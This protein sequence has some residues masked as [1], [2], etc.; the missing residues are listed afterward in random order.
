MTPL[1]WLHLSDLHFQNGDSFERNIVLEELLKDVGEQIQREQFCLD[2]IAVTGDIAYSGKT[3][4]Y[5]L[6]Q[7]YFDRL[8]KVTATPKERLFVVPGNHDLDRSTITAGARQIGENFDQQDIVNDVLGSTRDMKLMMRRFKAFQIFLKKYNLTRPLD[9]VPPPLYW[10]YEF[11]HAGRK[12]LLSGLNS[13]WI[14]GSDEDDRNRVVIGER[15]VRGALLVDNADNEQTPTI[16]IVLMHHPF[17]LLREFDE[18]I[19]AALLMD[20]CDFIL[21]G[22][23]HKTSLNQLTSPDNACMRIAGGAC[24]KSRKFPNTYNFVSLDFDKGLGRVIL[25]KFFN[26]RGGHWASGEGIYRN[27]PGGVW[28]FQVP[29]H[30]YPPLENIILVDEHGTPAKILENELS[31]RYLLESLLPEILNSQNVKKVRTDKHNIEIIFGSK[32]EVS[33]LDSQEINVGEQ[34]KILSDGTHLTEPNKTKETNSAESEKISSSYNP[35]IIEKILLN[36]FSDQELTMLCFDHFPLIYPQL[37]NNHKEKNVELILSYCFKNN[38]I[39]ELLELIQKY[40]PN[41]YGEYANRFWDG[42]K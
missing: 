27:A 4:E 35:A 26:E 21:H 38:K 33:I 19:S 5:K 14:C 12:I 7:E 24:Y 34:A 11:K 39:Q 40:K 15:Q 37:E 42:P 28:Q 20:G 3:N 10:N 36:A 2:F 16:R 17:D 32:Y 13:A 18:D 41:W 22:H 9:E 23:L 31:R 30:F 25:R 8:L 1:T 6:A 29:A